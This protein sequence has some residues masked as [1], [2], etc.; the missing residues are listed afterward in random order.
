MNLLQSIIVFFVSP[1]L[2][3]I[4]LAL[5]IYMIFSWLVALNIVNLRNQGM[6]QI[7]QLSRSIVEPILTPLRRFIPPLGGL[8]MAFFVAFLG[9][10]WMRQ[11]VLPSL[12][13]MLG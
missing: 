7:Y 1:V 10:V 3:F 2:M 9:L 5:I 13:N 6:A 12:V 8:D 11:Y 4:Q